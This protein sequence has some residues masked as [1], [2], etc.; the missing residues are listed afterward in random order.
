MSNA[1]VGSD[2]L[3][4]V[5]MFH[6]WTLAEQ[7]LL[8]ENV[9]YRLRDTGQGLNRVQP[10]PK[11]S[12]MM[13]AIL[14]RAQRSIGSWVG[15]SVIHM[16]DHN[17]PNALMFI[18]K[19][20]IVPSPSATLTHPPRR[21]VLAGLPHPP[22]DLQHARADPRASPRTPRCGRTS[23][24]EWGSPD[25]LARD[26][27]ADFFRHGF[28]DSGAGNYLDAGSCIDGRLT[29]AWN[30]CSTL[31]KKRFFPVFLLTGF[32]GFDGDW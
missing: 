27:L 26:I 18:G 28:D 32:I 14:N 13:H 11:T 30:W 22:P 12:R 10:P 19:A 17:V 1:G 31:E 16:G 21:Q 5:D 15:S 23:T 9:P 29:S 3:V 7:D 2:G 24:T 8:N 4:R 20:S 25:G 6:L